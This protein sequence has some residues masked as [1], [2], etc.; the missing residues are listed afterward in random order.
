MQILLSMTVMAWFLEIEERVGSQGG[1][2]R[3]LT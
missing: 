1:R 3:K 2:G